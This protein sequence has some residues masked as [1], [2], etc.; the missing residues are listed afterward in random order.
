M[1]KLVYIIAAVLTVSFANK[2]NAQVQTEAEVITLT[3]NL[4]TTMAL[5]MDKS[6]ITFNFVTLNE[7]KEGLGGYDNESY[8]SKGQISST[9]NWNLSYKAQDDFKHEDGKTIMPLDNVGLSAKFTGENKI[10]NYAEKNPLA[11]S[12]EETIILGHNG[13]DSNAGDAVANNFVI[14]YEMG[15][16]QSKMNNKS[17]FEQ[18]LKKGSY[19]TKVEFVAT[20]VL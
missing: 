15:T 16:K 4:E 1:K 5:S 8:S 19:S 9:A 18:D 20:E 2:V 6:D 12:K 10:K 13:S 17:I 3:A 7:Y 14:F 11:L